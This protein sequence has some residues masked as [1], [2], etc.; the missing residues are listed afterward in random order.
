MLC[1]YESLLSF[2]GCSYFLSSAVNPF[3]YGLFSKRFRQGYH[4]LRTKLKVIYSKTTCYNHS[5]GQGSAI[6]VPERRIPFHVIANLAFR[7]TSIKFKTRRLSYFHY[8]D[9]RIP[10]FSFNDQPYHKENETKDVDRKTSFSWLTANWLEVQL[11]DRTYNQSHEVKQNVKSTVIDKIN[12]RHF[13]YYSGQ[14]EQ[15]D[16]NG[17]SK[18]LSHGEETR[19][20]LN[21]ITVPEIHT[22][23]ISCRTSLI[24][25]RTYIDATSAKLAWI[26]RNNNDLSHF[27]TKLNHGGLWN[28]VNLAVERI[29]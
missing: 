18:I 27:I 22:D 29:Q 8:D 4:D 14:G 10:K 3:L 21:P 15:H 13:T 1:L 12:K 24:H 17:V 19:V 6:V 23:K 20:I 7:T 26:N 5:N 11:V 9:G 2:L 28:N 25:D 16:C